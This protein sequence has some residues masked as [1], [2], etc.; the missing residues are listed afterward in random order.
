MSDVLGGPNEVTGI[1]SDS[2]ELAVCS[3]ATKFELPLLLVDGT[4]TSGS[5]IRGKYILKRL[6]N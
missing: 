4:A 6:G 1:K 5:S 2:A 3:W